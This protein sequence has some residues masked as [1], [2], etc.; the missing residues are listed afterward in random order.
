MKPEMDIYQTCYS[1]YDPMN[2]NAREGG[3]EEIHAGTCGKLKYITKKAYMRAH[4]V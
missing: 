4:I 3:S 2:S 1:K